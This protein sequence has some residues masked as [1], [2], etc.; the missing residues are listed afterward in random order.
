[1][2][3]YTVHEPPPRTATKP[4]PIRS[5]S[6]SCATDSHFWAFLLGPLWMLWHRLWLVLLIYV[7]LRRRC[8]SGC[9][10][11]ALSG[12]VQVRGRLSDRAADRVR[13]GHAA[14]LD[15]TRR[16]W[17]QSRRGGGDDLEAAERR[18]FDAWVQ[19]ATRASHAAAAADHADRRSSPRRRSIGL[20]P[21]P[22][23]SACSR[24]R[25]RRGERRDRRL[26]LRQSALGR[27][28]V[29]ARRARKRRTSSRS[30]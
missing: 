16:G 23:S 25:E 2:A 30:W 4:R 24:S 27:Q 22:P 15:A 5:A 18:F 8:R 17:T 6:R 26:R 19:C 21:E 1:M 28:G 14:A 7:V 9:W 10:R 29:R 3:V 13:S 11:S 20:C 12:A